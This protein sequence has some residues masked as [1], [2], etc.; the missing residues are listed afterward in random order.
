M[1]AR[2]IE[3]VTGSF[4]DKKR[5]HRYKERKALL[6]APYRTATDGLERYIM[7]AGAISKGDVLAQMLEDLADLMEQGAADGVPVRGIVGEDPVDFAETFI[8]NYADGQWISKE[9]RRLIDA[10]D[11]SAAQDQA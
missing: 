2:W 6:P 4:E 1:A 3:Q 11:E 8:A 5:W 10:I 7:Y 9:R